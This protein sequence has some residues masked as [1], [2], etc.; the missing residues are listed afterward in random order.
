MNVVSGYER[1]HF[2]TPHY[3]SER[4]LQRAQQGRIELSY[5]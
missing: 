1:N 2:P 4:D 5:M 3:L